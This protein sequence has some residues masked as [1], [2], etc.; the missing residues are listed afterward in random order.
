MTY[1][2]AHVG[3]RTKRRRRPADQRPDRCRNPGRSAAVPSRIHLGLT[4]IATG[5]SKPLLVTNAGDGSDRLFVV[6]QTGR[7]RIIKA[8]KMLAVPF[9]DLSAS[10]SARGTA[11]ILAL[12]T[13]ALVTSFGQDQVGELYLTDGNGSVYRLTDS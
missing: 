9:L 4:K 11:P 6:E 5:L 2:S 13:N 7:I 3:H 12:D 1:D 8:G 10:V